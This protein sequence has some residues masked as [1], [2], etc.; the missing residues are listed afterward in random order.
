MRSEVSH[1]NRPPLQFADEAELEEVI[2]A[3][4]AARFEADA[5]R[6]R[7]RLISIETV[8]M[9]ALVAAAGTALGQP[10]LLVARASL[11]IGASCLATGL[12]LLGL[13]AWTSWLMTRFRDW[14]AS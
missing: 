1:P 2:E 6:W 13:S 11:L 5:L 4:L 3:R 9:M 14:K 12:L 8:M 10:V 7:F